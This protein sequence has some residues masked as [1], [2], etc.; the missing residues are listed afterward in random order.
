MKHPLLYFLLRFALLFLVLV[1]CDFGLGRLLQHY[2]FT[3]TSGAAARTTYAMEEITAE[4]LI[5]GSSRA[6]HHYVP[7]ILSSQL[8]MG[9]YNTGRDGNYIFYNLA[10][11][12]TILKRYTPEIIILDANVDIF[13]KTP[14]N[15]DRLASLLPYYET[16]EEIRSIVELRSRFEKWKLYSRIYP[17]NSLLGS[18]AIRNLES[19]KQATE[20]DG[21]VP[22]YDQ[23]EYDIKPKEFS[24]KVLDEKLIDGFRSFVQE[25]RDAGSE[26]FVI[27]SPFYAT[28]DE[29]PGLPLIEKICQEEGVHFKDDAQSEFFLSRGEL[30][31]DY[32]HLNHEGA[33]L[34]SEQIAGWIAAE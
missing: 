28:Y 24:H 3:Q 21:Y 6:S 4:G 25:A 1:I 33:M 19:G 13:H 10:V 16:H 30:F 7:E 18:I 22:I 9:F 5:F 27:I 23:W 29:V 15:Y 12:R 11:L 32:A 26:V 8:N 34:F 14:A 17:Y 31:G 2:Y 20:G